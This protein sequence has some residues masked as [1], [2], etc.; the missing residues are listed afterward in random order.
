MN[1]AKC[2][3]RNCTAAI[4]IQHENCHKCSSFVSKEY[5]NLF[6]DVITFTK[7]HLKEMKEMNCKFL[8]A[9]NIQTFILNA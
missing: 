3:N 4:N 8:K 9:P 7:Y 6:Q 2:P 5:R 1:A